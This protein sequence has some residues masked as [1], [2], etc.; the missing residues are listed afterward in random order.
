MKA[1]S[2][3]RIGPAFALALA[4]AS[5]PCRAQDG[6]ELLRAEFWADIEPVAGVGDEWPVGPET[7][8]SRVL[9]ESAWVFGGMVWGFEFRYSPFDKTRAIEERFD[10]APIQSL[11]PK[12]LTFAPGARRSTQDAYYS[13][14]EYAPDASLQSLM[15]SYAS[16]PWK[17]AQ[18]I[19]KADMSLGVKGRRAAYVDGLRAAVRSLLQ[20]LVP[21]KPRLVRGRVVLDRPPS[22]AIIGGCYT[23][24]VRVRVMVIEVI[25]YKVY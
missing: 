11:D 10:L 8:R 9:D 16:E 21:N 18:G 19:G 4:L 22:M 25:P 17:G 23:V 1:S 15:Q 7:L 6:K 5:A 3:A 2:A 24:Q 12:E 20:G 13:F 14:V